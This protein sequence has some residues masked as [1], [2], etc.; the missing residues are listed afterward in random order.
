MICCFTFLAKLKSGPRSSCDP[1]S[2]F[3]P[4]YNPSR[5]LCEHRT[6]PPPES[7]CDLQ[8]RRQNPPKNWLPRKCSWSCL[9]SSRRHFSSHRNCACTQWK[10]WQGAPNLPGCVQYALQ[11]LL[12]LLNDFAK[13]INCGES[14]IKGLHETFSWTECHHLFTLL[15]LLNCRQAKEAKMRDCESGKEGVASQTEQFS[16]HFNKRIWILQS[17]AKEM[18]SSWLM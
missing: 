14:V 4:L 13:N 7:K 8:H 9:C 1:Q 2:S 11:L 5:N 10:L 15:E 3:R 18:I 6:P 16:Y 12:H 17:Y